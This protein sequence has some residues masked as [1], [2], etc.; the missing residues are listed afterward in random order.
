LNPR[1]IIAAAILALAAHSPA[2]EPEEAGH[3]HGPDGRHIAVASTFGAAT[4]KQILS[5]HDLRIEGPDGKSVLGA[6]VHSVIHRKGDANAVVHREH[7]SYEDENEVYG[8]HMMYKEPG[9]YTIVE[10]VTLPDKRELT[11]EFPIW[12]P[13]PAGPTAAAEEH[14]ESGPNIPLIIGASVLGLG[15]LYGAFRLGRQSAGAASIALV[16]AF[17]TVPVAAWAQDEEAGHMH[18][19][20]GRHIAVAATFGGG[21][22]EPL[23]AFPSADLTESATKQVDDIEFTLSIENEEIETDP[24]AVQMPDDQA[25]AIG[26]ETVP[27][28]SVAGSNS[29]VV[30]GQ[31]RPNP[32]GVVT[33]NARVP[34][35]VVQVG[36]TPG[37]DIAA[38][39]V[40]AVIES[41]QVV[42]AQAVLR[43]A[44]A[45]SASAKAGFVRAQ[46]EVQA[47][48][49]RLQNAEATLQRQKRLARE[50]AFAN[51][52]VESARTR[53]AEVEGELAEA[54]TEVRS[55]EATA[56][57]LRQGF[58]TGVVARNEADS[59]QA[60]AEAARTR[61]ATAERQLSIAKETL[62]R[63]QRIQE[64]GL[65]NATQIQEAEAD[66]RVARAGVQS[67]RSQLAQAKAEQ[68]RAE[69][70]I[71][72]ARAVLTQI[73]AAGEGGRVTMRTPIG[74]EV[75][76]RPVSVGQTVSEG[77]LLA[78][79]LNSGVLWVEGEVFERDLPKVRV[80]QK[81][82][83]T[84]DA[85]PGRSFPGVVEYIGGEVDPVSRAV[86]VRTVVK[87]TEEVLKPNMFAQVV[88]GGSGEAMV[89]VPAA[90]LQEDGG[91]QIVFVE[92][93]HGSYRRTV[94][95]VGSTLGERV[96]I[97][98]G[99]KPGEKVVTQGAYQLLA[100]AKGG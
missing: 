36:V 26:L 28:E 97:T 68:V 50:G 32:N 54:R 39:H 74:G 78:R 64:Q 52:A 33:V 10:K 58:E 14:H 45:D 24:N 1:R 40:V 57:R 5:H 70:A 37:E 81:V 6:D 63:E 86:R 94:V 17:G 84:A 60:A 4:G 62:S 85:V 99:L 51:P 7:N 91:S 41:G 25:A 66:V 2:Q 12:V 80:G 92:A 72:S 98:S 90:A 20:D 42:E 82:T 55:L 3:M 95:Q 47:A 48:G 71:R 75:E 16:L 34:G 31:V 73:G 15:L 44:E 53:I 96:L 30:T 29:L 21:G 22:A 59:A 87:Q 67:A 49:T 19:P 11:V 83:V 18:G 65:R 43:R 76:A 56:R 13:A 77:E 46:T 61:V 27:V 93:E 9:E 38:G 69:G 100:K 89:A 79:V 23:K 8:S 35:R 88:L